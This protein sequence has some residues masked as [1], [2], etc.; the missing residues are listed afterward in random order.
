MLVMQFV[1]ALSVSKTHKV[2]QWVD[3]YNAGRAHFGKHCFDETSMQTLLDS[4][5]RAQQKQFNR[6]AT[7]PLMSLAA[8]Q[9]SFR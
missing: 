1:V 6:T 3:T 8:Q 9:S 7:A 2:D 4:M 5:S